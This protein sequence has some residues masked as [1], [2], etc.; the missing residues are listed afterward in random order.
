MTGKL[1]VEL[2]AHWRAP[3]RAR[4]ADGVTRAARRGVAVQRPGDRLEQRRLPGPVGA[5]DAGKA[6]VERDDGVRVLAEVLRLDAVESHSDMVPRRLRCRRQAEPL[7]SYPPR[8]GSRGR[9]R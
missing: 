2:H 8:A 3:S 9:V 5:D 4:E 7:R 1:E 6:R